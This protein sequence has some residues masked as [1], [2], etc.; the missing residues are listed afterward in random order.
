MDL[1]NE[2]LLNSTNVGGWGFAI[3]D[4]FNNLSIEVSITKNSK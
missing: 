1:T 4:V 3:T 2:M